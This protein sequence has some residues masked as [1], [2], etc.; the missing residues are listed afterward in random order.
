MT[1][2]KILIT[3][4]TGFLGYNILKKLINFNLDLYSLSTKKPKKEKKIK[5]VKYII[6][7]LRNKNNLYKKIN[8]DFRYVI[9]LGG[10]VDH[11][12]KIK[13]LQSHFHGCKNLVDFFKNKNLLNFIQI[14]SSLEYGLSKTPN[15][16]DSYCAP[17]GNYGLSKLKAS[18]YITKVAK[19]NN[20]PFTILR[21]YQI[22]GPYQSI[23]RLVP[24]TVD[25]CLKDKNFPCSK[26]DQN[27][28]FLYVE[29]FVDLIIKILKTKASNEIYNVGSGKPIK[30]KNVIKIIKSGIGLGTPEFGRIKM[31]K[32]EIMNS[33]PCIDKV[34]NKFNWAPKTS[35]ARGIKKTIKFYEVKKN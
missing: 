25:A 11:K 8:F 31:R 1:A 5:G 35:F 2:K 16:E 10:Y 32:D 14:G 30:I 33:Y 19:I 9:N 22:Y 21:L 23:N 27:R 34:K 12:K 24:I 4:G 6:C 13:T 17:R 3:G 28:D 18:E 26:G 20:L 7:D 29:D 15:K